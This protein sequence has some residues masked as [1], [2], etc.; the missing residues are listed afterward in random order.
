MILP[1]NSTG[2]D[3]AFLLDT[4]TSIGGDAN[5]KLTLSFIVAVFKAI[6][7]S[8]QI[9]VAF[10]IFGGSTKV[11]FGFTQYTSITEVESAVLGVSMV[12][13]TCTAGAAISTCR[14]DV[15]ASA[16]TELARILVVM[17]AGRS[18]DSLDEP[19]SAIK[20][21]GIKVICIGMGGGYDEGQLTVIASSGDYILKA[22]SYADLSGLTSR[23]V[24]L[25]TSSKFVGVHVFEDLY[26]KLTRDYL[27]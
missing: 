13:G 23:C 17:M 16:R 12:G 6:G 15:F 4:S 10:V 26:H 11:V 8:A 2:Y 1:I 25:F 7:V 9:R 20:G 21:T 18:S 3:V 19:S 24:S 5:F 22:A 14:S 27:Y